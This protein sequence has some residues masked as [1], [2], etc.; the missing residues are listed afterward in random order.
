[1]G[2]ALL[3]WRLA[4]RD[5]RRRPIEAALLLVAIMGATTTLTLG[6]VLH[7]VI[8]KPYQATREATAGPDVVASV[9][10]TPRRYGGAAADT[11]SLD[12]LAKAPGVVAHSG[13][14]PV[15]W[16]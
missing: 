15:T 16:A 6:L 7:G 2:R 11:S 4:A 8:D 9:S 13:P 12:T 10:P 5:L 3:L 1:M 14:F